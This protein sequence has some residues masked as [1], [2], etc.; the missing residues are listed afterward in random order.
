MNKITHYRLLRGMSKSELSY[1]CGLSRQ[2]IYLIEK[3]ISRCSI[4]SLRKVAAALQ[5]EVRDLI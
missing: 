5:V 4:K 2:F 1:Q 3:D